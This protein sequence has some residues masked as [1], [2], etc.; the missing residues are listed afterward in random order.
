M[1]SLLQKAPVNDVGM[2]LALAVIASAN[3]PLLLLNGALEV[4]AASTSF[5]RE[6]EFD[7]DKMVGRRFAELGDGEWAHPQLQSL[8]RATVAGMAEVEAYEIDLARPGRPTHRLILNAHKLDYGEGEKVRLLLSIV[9]V[10]QARCNEKLKDE[11]LLEKAVLLQ[12]LQHRV[13]NSL[14][15]IAS[16]LMQSAR[17][18][19]SEEARGHLRSAHDRVMSIASVQQQLAASS[20]NEVALRPYLVQLCHSLAASM[21]RDPSMLDVAVDSDETSVMPD[22]SISLGLIVTELVINALKHAFPE[23][24]TGRITVGYHA[25]GD[26]WTLSVSDDGVGMPASPQKAKAGLGTTIVEALAKQ[27]HA[28]VTVSS[29][30]PGTQVTIRH[31]EAIALAMELRGEPPVT[32]V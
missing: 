13:A 14:Q 20:L 1:T 22:I 24:R 26:A 19:V 31:S 10:T 7:P 32:A 12:E 30:N 4:I 16:I 29:A 6:F 11:L 23:G 9:D 15:I 8:L 17:K 28:A 3:A 5:C 27:L 25:D 21:I 18:V 2:S